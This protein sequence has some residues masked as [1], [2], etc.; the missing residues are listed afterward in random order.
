MFDPHKDVI[1]VSMTNT[2]PE[3]LFGAFPDQVR[4]AVYADLGLMP[5]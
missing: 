4:D 1:I 3:G 5:G 2:A